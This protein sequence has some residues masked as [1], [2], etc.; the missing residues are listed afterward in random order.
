MTI[1][2]RINKRDSSCLNSFCHNKINGKRGG[3]YCG[4]CRKRISRLKD[5]VKYSYDNKKYR[6]RNRKT[7]QFP[8]GIPF[9]ISLA[10][11][12]LWCFKV[13]YIKGAGR[14]VD[15]YDCDRIREDEGYHED[16]I[17]KLRKDKN[18][19]KYHKEKKLIYQWQDGSAKVFEQ[20]QLKEEEKYF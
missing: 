6:C 13:N 10:F 18:I 11:W 12:R 7:K 2:D 17:Q 14:T 15:C 19:K 8:D 4:T 1:I 9:T 3:K 5:P 20:P 16:N